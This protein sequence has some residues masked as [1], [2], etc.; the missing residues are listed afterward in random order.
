MYIFSIGSRRAI[1]WFFVCDKSGRGSCNDDQQASITEDR[2]HANTG[3]IASQPTGVSFN[4]SLWVE[5]PLQACKTLPLNGNQTHRDHS[6]GSQSSNIRFG[7]VGRLQPT[8][9]SSRVG[10]CTSKYRVS[11]TTE[12]KVREGDERRHHNVRYLYV[13]RG[14][15]GGWGAYTEAGLGIC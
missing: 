5:Y 4:R 10:G 14:Y 12:A 11:V 13:C 3:L 15:H 6:V 1:T 2:L 7:T 8:A 9:A